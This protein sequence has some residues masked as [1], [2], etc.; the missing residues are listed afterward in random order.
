MPLMP[1]TVNVHM[2]QTP[3]NSPTHTHSYRVTPPRAVYMHAKPPPVKSKDE[4][5]LV[6]I[7]EGW[8]DRFRLV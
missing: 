1:C 2:T 3:H 6:W 8:N 5:C 7:V 4:K